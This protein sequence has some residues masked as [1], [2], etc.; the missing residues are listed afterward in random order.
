MLEKEADMEKR[1]IKLLLTE[2]RALRERVELL[3]RRLGNIKSGLPELLLSSGDIGSTLLRLLQWPGEKTP[4]SIGQGIAEL[5]RSSRNYE[6]CLSK[7]VVPCDKRKGEALSKE[8][9]DLYK[10]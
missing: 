6:R 3:E 4:E 2:V 7:G 8:K 1:G 9:V 10:R 5:E